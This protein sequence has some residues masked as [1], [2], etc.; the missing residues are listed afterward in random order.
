M[1]CGLRKVPGRRETPLTLLNQPAVAVVEGSISF[2]CTE[3]EPPGDRI[4]RAGTRV[5]GGI[6]PNEPAIRCRLAL[7]THQQPRSQPGMHL[8]N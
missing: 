4:S 2:Q 7:L 3:A 8:M 1:A 6:V 5:S